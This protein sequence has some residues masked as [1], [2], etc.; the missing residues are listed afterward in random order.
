[1]ILYSQET[2]TCTQEKQ[3]E[4]VFRLCS[5]QWGGIKCVKKSKL[6]KWYKLLLPIK[7][8]FIIRSLSQ[9]SKVEKTNLSSKVVLL[10]Q[11]F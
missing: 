6:D 11:P 8:F 9:M 7:S 4:N 5:Y 1:M 3:L 10:K 2:S